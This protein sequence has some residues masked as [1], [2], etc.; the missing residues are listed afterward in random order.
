MEQQSAPQNTPQNSPVLKRTYN[1]VRDSSHDHHSLSYFAMASAPKISAATLPYSCDLRKTKSF[2]PIYDQSTL[3]SC[4]SN[5]WCAC[6]GEES[7]DHL[8]GSRL[9]HYY[10]ERKMDKDISEDAG[11]TLTTGS[12]VLSKIGLCSEGSWPYNIEKFTESPPLECY[13]EALKHKIASAQV[14]P[15][16]L[17][18]LKQAISSGHPFVFGI[19]VYDSFESEET[20]KTGIVTLPLS[21][22]KCV[23]GHAVCA[24]GYDDAK[25]A[26]I[27]RNSWG[28]GWGDKG[29][30]YL[31]Y[32]YIT[33]HNLAYDFWK[34]IKTS[35]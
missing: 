18:H 35:D 21:S 2:P 12:K 7:H 31:P 25:K 26:F 33:N 30:F 9:F 8:G 1:L 19:A 34:I 5:A 10:N 14:I 23:G 17:L 4:T 6:Y 32:S 20:A 22:E 24:I 3:G 11:S 27:V 29:Y 16:D 28:T 15:Q 13:Q